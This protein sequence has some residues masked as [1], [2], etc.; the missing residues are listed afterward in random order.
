MK[1]RT[2]LILIIIFVLIL[3]FG[4]YYYLFIY[5]KPA[6][7]TVVIDNTDPK[8]TSKNPFSPF[9]NDQTSSSTNPD[10]SEPVSSNVDANNPNTTE[11]PK[12]RL[13]SADPVSGAVAISSASTTI[14]RYMDRGLG[15]IIE[16]K[17]DG[18]DIVK[19]SNKTIPKIYQTIWAR[20]GMSAFVKYIPESEDGF[21][22]VVKTNYLYIVDPPK[23]KVTATSIGTSTSTLE[24]IPSNTLKDTFFSYVNPDMKN[25]VPAPTT[26]KEKAFAYLTNNDSGSTG[27][28]YYPITDKFV[29]TFSSPLKNWNMFWADK[30][31]ILLANKATGYGLSTL[32]SYDITKKT[33]SRLFS[34]RGLTV[35]PN[36]DYKKIAYSV[37]SNNVLSLYIYDVTTKKSEKTILPTLTEKCVWGTRDTNSLY[38]GAPSNVPNAVFPDSWYKGINLFTDKIWRLDTE[39]GETTLMG[40]LYALSKKSLDV[41]NPTLDPKEGY[42]IF[43]DKHDMSLWSLEL[44]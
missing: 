41:I 22:E 34:G 16:T 6:D 9:G 42:M 8:N 21:N 15:H 44:K 4:T 27:Y 3:G 1:N 2:F 18:Q 31:T 40:D 11:L 28:I 39:T 20:D 43:N 35:L 10:G 38:C 32:F 33:T 30:N 19:V 26:V 14:I 5:N 36:P 17:T 13:I 23:P 29:Q 37:T 7:N 12:L 24:E 25:V